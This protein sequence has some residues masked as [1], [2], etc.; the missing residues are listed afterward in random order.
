MAEKL[1]D[2]TWVAPF[3]AVLPD[4]TVLV[5]NESVVK[6][7]AG[8]AE[9]SDHWRPVKRARKPRAK[10]A[11]KAEPAPT[12]GPSESPAGSES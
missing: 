3:E 6:V 7:P 1:V 12:P 10:K 5:P 9:E 2:A 4:K 11:A 8:E